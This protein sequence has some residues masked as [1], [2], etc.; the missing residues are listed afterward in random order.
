MMTV[1][2]GKWM[3][4][5]LLLWVSLAQGA[6]DVRLVTHWR[7]DD[8]NGTTLANSISGQQN[9]VLVGGLSFDNDSAEGIV[10][11]ALHFDG[12]DDAIILD[13]SYSMPTDVFTIA[14]WF[15]P[16]STMN[17][18]SRQCCFIDMSKKSKMSSFPCVAFNKDGYGEIALYFG[19]DE[20]KI[21]VSTKTGV[22]NA[23]TWYHI[24]I[25]SDQSDLKMYVNGE[26][27]DTVNAPGSHRSFQVRIGITRS[28][29]SAFCGKLDDIR[30]YGTALSEE[31]LMQLQPM[32]ELMM[33]TKSVEQV[34]VMIKEKP[35]DAI[36]FLSQRIV[37]CEQWSAK[38]P[39]K[40][41]SLLREL[42]FDV[43]FLLV[44]AKQAA[45]F[46][47]EDVEA[48]YE[49]ARRQG[50]PSTSRRTSVLLWLCETDR[51][52]HY[53]SLVV[54]LNQNK[55]CYL[56]QAVLKAEKMILA[57]Q[58]SKAIKFLHSNLALFSRWRS[59][60]PAEQVPAQDALP[61]LYYQLA[62]AK[63]ADG[64][65]KEDIADAYVK[66]FVPSRSSYVT[67]RSATLIWL[68]DNA[69]RNEQTETIKLLLSNDRIN[70][71]FEEIL[72]GLCTYLESKHDAVQF[73]RLVGT[74]GAND[75]YPFEWL[76]HV[77]SCL[78]DRTNRWAKRHAAYVDSEP[79][80]RFGMDC[81]TAHRYAAD[82]KFKAAADLYRNLL[83]RCG[84]QDDKALV[85]FQLCRCLFGA[86]SYQQ[87]IAELD[88]FIAGDK[89][90]HANLVREAMLM[91]AH[92]YMRLGD[93]ARARVAF[94]TFTKKYPEASSEPKVN[95]F[96]G[97]CRMLE[98]SLEDAASIFSQVIKN[99]PNHPYAAKA[100]MCM[101]RMT[102]T[103]G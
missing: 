23:S 34:E 35:Q 50:V 4:L 38:N 75:K 72:R 59:A 10:G 46:S 51:T 15:N 32:A 73:E 29:E 16:D 30:V 90:A 74:V 96:L 100:R 28:Q 41:V 101:T 98:G 26:L 99:D 88:K 1:R 78:S 81:I 61:A 89:G 33:P 70:A 91:K 2:L 18:A 25:T 102:G 103:R 68:F 13:K 14:F 87:T 43:H 82:N 66:T 83:D 19:D 24:A 11:N 20:E 60:H 44:R 53:E 80:L 17:I 45:G 7:L 97:Y 62:K 9:G 58:S 69:G 21:G 65:K 31:Q 77:N 40:H 85:H 67:K 52:Q 5:V 63:E 22:W 3:S 94:S 92:A 64:A 42:L 84:P 55:S 36:D 12:T 8:T 76:A 56:R 6:L 93:P 54:A 47:N 49:R 27:Q 95:F 57:G 79:R 71:S 37:E 39:G 86:G 48:E